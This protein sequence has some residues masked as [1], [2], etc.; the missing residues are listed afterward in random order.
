VGG[1][2]GLIM[3]MWNVEL[4]RGLLLKTIFDKDKTFLVLRIESILKHR[5]Y[6]GQNWGLLLH[7][8]MSSN[9]I[10]DREPFTANFLIYLMLQ[11]TL[12]MNFGLHMFHYK[13]FIHPL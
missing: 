12:E 11:F 5:K 2:Q 6:F 1:L 4:G 13:V 7:L 3:M 8:L 10:E 9:R